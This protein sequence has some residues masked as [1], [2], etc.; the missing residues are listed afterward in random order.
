[1]PGCGVVVNEVAEGVNVGDRGREERAAGLRDESKPDI[2]EETS[3]MVNARG[4][5]DQDT[6]QVEHSRVK[7]EADS[8]VEN[9]RH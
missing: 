6:R 1:M 7:R 5:T 4:C 3:K 2:S 8:R 9:L